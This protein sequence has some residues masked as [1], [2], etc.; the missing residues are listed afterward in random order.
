[1]ISEV[2]VSEGIALSR[3]REAV[4]GCWMCNHVTMSSTIGGRSYDKLLNSA[5]H[6]HFWKRDVGTRQSAAQRVNS[7]LRQITSGAIAAAVKIQDDKTTRTRLE[8]VPLLFP[9][10][11]LTIEFLALKCE[12]DQGDTAYAR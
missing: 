5:A 10:R 3:K 11:Y 4:T 9:Q 6:L 2:I 12:R 8:V 1:M 7:Y